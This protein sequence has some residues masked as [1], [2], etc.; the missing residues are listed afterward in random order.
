MVSDAVKIAKL[1]ARQ[2]DTDLLL[3]LITTP[4][5]EFAGLTLLIRQM[6]KTKSPN[7]LGINWFG[8]DL[9]TTTVFNV[10]CGIIAIQALSPLVPA[11]VAGG[12]DLIK[13]L[14]AIALLK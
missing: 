8:M 3:K 7:F 10:G 4:I 5:V 6:E 2:H 11:I 12:Q 14:P 13:T 9:D 1:Q